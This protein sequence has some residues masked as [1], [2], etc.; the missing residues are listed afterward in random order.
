MLDKYLADTRSDI[1][2]LRQC[3]YHYR[4]N[5]VEAAL[6]FFDLQGML[7]N[8]H[9]VIQRCKYIQVYLGKISVCMSYVDLKDRR[10]ALRSMY[11]LVVI[12]TSVLMLW[13]KHKHTIRFIG[14]IRL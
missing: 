12:K 1:F 10:E 11:F 3:M 4:S 8:F 6:F 7:E 9:D 5:Q 14:K 13:K 2:D